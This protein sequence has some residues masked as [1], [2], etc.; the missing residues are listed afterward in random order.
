MAHK[1]INPSP[2]Q[3][4]PN[5]TVTPPSLANDI[6]TKLM[7]L[8][9]IIAFALFANT[10]MHGFVLDDE[11]VITK[12]RFVM[13]GL[14]G[15]SKLFTTYYWEGYWSNNAG[16]YRPLSLVMFAVEWSIS[17]NNPFIHHAVQVLL[18]SVCIV[19][20]FRVMR[21]LL[22]GM[23]VWVP[24][25]V[26]LL[27]AVHPIHTEVVAN[28]KS[29]DEI[30]CFLF[31]LLTFHV[32]LTREMNTWPNRLLAAGLFLLCLLSKEAGILFVP[33]IGLYYF[34]VRK[35][36]VKQAV[37]NILPLVATGIAWL[38]LHQSIILGSADQRIS[39]TYLDNSLVACG[40]LERMTT[41]TVILGHYI[42]KTVLPL[43]LSYD[44]SFN[45]IPCVGLES[46]MVWF[47]LTLTAGLLFFAW[48]CRN[49]RAMVS[50]GILFFFISIAL[51]TNIFTLIGTTMGDR[52]LFT[53]VLGIILAVV[54][55]A[56]L[57]FEKNFGQYPK[58]AL[59]LFVFVA[60]VFAGMSFTRN[61]DW[62]SNETLFVHD[63]DVAKHSARTQF[64]KAAILMATLPADVNQ[65]QAKLP[66][67]IAC[68][69]A[70]LKI[71]PNDFGSHVNLGVCHYRMKQYDLS[72]QHTRSAIA[73]NPADKTTY[74]NLA[75]AYFKNNQ[76]D[77]AIHYYNMAIAQ[78]AA[79]EN[80]Y[81]F[82]GA[83]YFGM[84]NYPMAEKTFRQGLDL[85]PSNTEMWMNYGSSLAIQKRLQEAANAFAEILKLDANNKQAVYMLAK[86]YN[87]MGNKEQS[88]FY[89]AKYN[90][91]AK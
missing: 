59:W 15:I 20:L 4:A 83:A 56:Q 49:T 65:Q 53:P 91:M 12:N 73:I 5:K 85:F 72:I 2:R 9:G 77:S 67:V 1:K 64:N 47:A 40:P 29:R 6:S 3:S 50:F 63:A 46:P 16:L 43:Q 66:K 24:F 86:V 17:P 44:Y 26:T 19:V 58:A 89:L 52:L 10:L 62:K 25:S 54:Y 71:D 38:A 87:E 57:F 79:T 76:T 42:L 48:R 84:Q 18:Y 68:F 80:T 88:D 7:W 60:V 23:S 69:D 81:N 31:F 75:D 8:L 30:L 55:A 39:Y 74:G 33:I 34:L 22:P 32:M 82:M 70:A 35:L 78:G 27:F 28:I 61:A 51:V 13:E 36:S 14:G 11:A 90:T 41:G 37:M 21:K 45:Q